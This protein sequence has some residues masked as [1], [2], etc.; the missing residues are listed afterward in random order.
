MSLAAIFTDLKDRT[1]ASCAPDSSWQRAALRAGKHALTHI[2]ARWRTSG[3]LFNQPAVREPIDIYDRAAFRKFV[4]P[5]SAN[6]T[7]WTLQDAATCELRAARFVLGM[8][9]ESP[10]LRRDFPQ[11]V[12]E[13]VNGRF[14]QWLCAAGID[15]LGLGPR[16]IDHIQKAF[17]QGLGDR[18]R[19]AFD[20]LPEVRRCFPLALTPAGCKP[21]LQWLLAQG[22]KEYGFL[23]EEIWWFLQESAEDPSRGIVATYLRTPEWQRLFPHGLTRFGR[24]A[25]LRWIRDHYHI[26]QDWL[27]QVQL[28]SLYSPAEEL[29]L[30]YAAW[31][32]GQGHRGLFLPNDSEA[33]QFADWIQT[34]KQTQTA[35]APSWPESAGTGSDDPLGVNI[36]AHFCHPSGLQQAAKLTVKSLHSEDI[37]V[38]CRDV[39]SAPMFDV[40]H[41]SQYLGL[42]TFPITLLPVA[43][44][45]V[46]ETF[47]PRGGLAPRTGVYRIALWF[48]ELETIPAEWVS[49]AQGV[50]EIWAP[51]RFIAGAMRPIMPV[52][53]VDMLPAAELGAVPSLQRSHFALPQDQFLFLFSFDMSSV[54]ERKNP[55]GLIRA[56]Q[57]AF[58]RD[59]RF[60]LVIKVT[61]GH[62]EPRNFRRLQQAAR[63]AGVMLIDRIL[64]RDETYALMNAC[65]AYV[66]LHRSE[67]FGY[68]MAEAMLLGKPVIATNYSGN[69]DFMTPANSL[70][71]DYQLA[72]LAQDYPPY[73]R[74]AVWAEP[75]IDH[76]AQLMRW[77]VDHPREAA[78]LGER[79]RDD[80]Q[81]LLSPAAVGQRMAQRLRDIHATRLKT[82]VSVRQVA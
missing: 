22:K 50:H 12:T 70:L 11:A 34:Q 24:Q 41:R 73:P 30:A 76:A 51:T 43:P 72:P 29:R 5:Y 61:R 44:A 79:G 65:D 68:T 31:A 63:A 82:P 18:I 1:L 35:T 48:W 58:G 74:G 21:F 27:N 56:Y 2:L 69:V 15:E 77:I 40:P 20:H 81:R 53:V 47:Y 3:T 26:R 28:P 75:S 46:E 64:A 33:A 54:M 67:G 66:S 6:L 9:R 80:V 16:A 13:G 36:L 52:P 10:E 59:P 37:R 14:C 71:V 45:P 17:R 38:S 8:L 42:E 4:Q 25:L 39:Y 32:D 55:L 19:Q 57:R 78:I 62:T 23:D 49:Y 60:G 7:D